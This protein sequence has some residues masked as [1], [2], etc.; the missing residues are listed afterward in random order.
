M[1]ALAINGSPHKM[2]NTEILL[3]EV[4]KPLDE[5][6][7]ETE[8]VHVGG[9]KVKGCIACYKCFENKD[10][11]C[12]VT[13][14]ALNSCLEKILAADA[15]IMG[16]PTYFSDVTAEIKGLIDRTGLVAVA[17]GGLLY[18]KIGAAVVALRRGGST[19]AFDSINHMFMISGMIVPGSSYWNMG[20]GLHPGEVTGDVEAMRNMRHLGQAIA[21]VGKA[22][23]P[24]KDDYPKMPELPLG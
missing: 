17:N 13:N 2:G 15:V 5:A 1:K 7:W 18:G 24:Y 22:M 20:F 9:G 12:V 23:Q 4:L 11:R 21:C 10:R 19:H 8:C 3:R 16:T 14:D 6:G